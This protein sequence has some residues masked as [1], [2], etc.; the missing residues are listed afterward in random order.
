MS[1]NTKSEYENKIFSENTFL[2]QIKKNVCREFDFLS[3]YYIYLYIL[4]IFIYTHIP[5]SAYP[6]KRENPSVCS[7]STVSCTSRV[8]HVV[9]ARELREVTAMS[10]GKGVGRDKTT[11]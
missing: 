8:S 7:F 5:S 2:A 1:D 4:Y 3:Q 9:V 6:T 10:K 11:R